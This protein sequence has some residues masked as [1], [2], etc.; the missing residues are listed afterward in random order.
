MIRQSLAL[1]SLC[2]FGLAFDALADS[3][4]VV[5]PPVAQVSGAALEF[6]KTL[7]AEL[8]HQA[9]PSHSVL[10]LQTDS[11]TAPAHPPSL[12]VALGSE[13]LL[14][15]TQPGLGLLPNTPV[16]CALMSQQTYETTL[17]RFK[18][19]ASQAKDSH[20]RALKLT[21][22]YAN[23]PLS[24]Q[25]ALLR[26][27]LPKAQDLGVLWTPEASETAEG[28]KPS[29]SLLELKQATNERHLNLRIETVQAGAPVYKPLRSLLGQV[30][31]LWALPNDQIYNPASFQNILL[32]SIRAGVPMMGFSAAYVRAGAM[33]GVY[34]TP[35]AMAR[36]AAQ[37]VQ[38]MLVRGHTA[39]L[40]VAPQFPK[41]FEV[42]VNQAVARSMG[43]TL[44]AAQLQTRLESLERAP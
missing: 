17:K 30:D 4:W 15:L 7:V 12:V 14:S 19:M 43:Y 25:L 26:L 22:L 2:G 21:A 34:A 40:A 3:V 35:Q 23:Q 8:Q 29:S 9:L 13:A 31:V 27:A 5:V 28:A 16:L 24:R 37:M 36:Q 20:L 39:G 38:D 6:E 18:A 33:L 1:L 44:D 11:L 32:S 10:R 41:S 42:G